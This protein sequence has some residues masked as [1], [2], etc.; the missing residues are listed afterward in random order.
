MP[1]ARWRDRLSLF[2]PS[3]P[4]RIL[5]QSGKIFWR[6][7]DSPGAVVRRAWKPPAGANGSTSLAER[8]SL[9][10]AFV[11]DHVLHGFD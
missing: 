3:R 2:Q 4:A 7:V 1:S 6:G 11:Q 10:Q 8:Q 9:G 5:Q